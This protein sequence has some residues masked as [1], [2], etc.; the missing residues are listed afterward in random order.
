MNGGDLGG[1]LAL[2]ERVMLPLRF[3][4]PFDVDVGCLLQS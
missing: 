3:E 4:L 2:T 1:P